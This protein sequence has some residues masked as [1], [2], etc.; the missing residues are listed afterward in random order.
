MADIR[1]SLANGYCRGIGDRPLYPEFWRGPGPAALYYPPLGVT[2]AELK[3]FSGKGRK[4]TFGAGAAAPTW[5]V[6]R[7]GPQLSFDGGDLIECGTEATPAAS[8]FTLWGQ[9]T[10][11]ISLVGSGLYHTITCRGSVYDRGFGIHYYGKV[12]DSKFEVWSRG[13]SLAIAVYQHAIQVNI[14]Y[15]VVGTYDGTNLVCWLNGV[16]GTPSAGVDPAKKANPFRIGDD[17]GAALT[18]NGAIGPVGWWNRVLSP[19]AIRLLA[20]DPLAPLRRKPA[21]AYWFVGG[22]EGPTVETPATVVAAWSALAPTLKK[23]LSL[24]L[25]AATWS[26]PA[27]T[28]K[29]RLTLPLPAGTWSAPAPTLKK[30]LALLLP[31]ATWSVPAP[32]LSKCLSLPNPQAAWSVS[33]PT[34]DKKLTAPAVEAAWSV[35]AP[36]VKKRLALPLPT[37]AWSVP[38][39]ILKKRLSLPLPSAT[40][41]VPAPTLKKRLALPLPAATWSVPAPTLKKRLGLPAV[42]SAW[43]VPAVTTSASAARPW[44]AF[45]LNA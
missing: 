8:R 4:G 45:L 44:L 37:S 17:N 35:P 34:L 25:P 22:G 19:T 41:S 36:T 39:S 42:E 20:S 18:W 28:L 40:W 11:Y 3:D 6:G 31:A 15:S 33:T 27:P 43:S 29:K 26:V 38:V 5:G 23:R 12:G 10:T 1:P 32:T 9:C 30:R 14:P 21:P 16:A 2:G 7:Y 24:P 13:V